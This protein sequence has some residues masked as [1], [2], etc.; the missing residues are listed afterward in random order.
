MLLRAKKRKE[1][2]DNI[3][4][5]TIAN[6]SL[7][8]HAYLTDVLLKNITKCLPQFVFWKDVDSVY[9][10]CN[11]N[12]AHFIGLE[13]SIDIVGKTD[14]DIDWL[15][16]GHTADFFQSGDKDVLAGHPIY[17]QEEVL[18]LPN[19]NKIHTQ[20]SKL[21]IKGQDGEILGVIGCF[22]DITEL[23]RKEK[24]A[25]KARKEAQIAN[26]SRMNFIS[27]MSHDLRTPLTGMLGMAKIISENSLD[28]KIVKASRYLIES[29]N[30]LLN[31]L[32]EIIE[33][34]QIES[35]H[36]PLKFSEIRIRDIIDEVVSLFKPT[37]YQKPVSLNICFDPRIPRCLIGDQ[38]RVQRVL[39]NL[40]SNAIKFTNQ[41]AIHITVDVAKFEENSLTIR[42]VVADTGIG[43]DKKDH[44]SIFTQFNRLTSSSSGAYPGSGLGLSIVER[45]IKDMR[46]SINLESEILKGSSFIC[47]I[48]FE[49]LDKNKSNG[50]ADFL[51]EK[52]HVS[53]CP[54]IQH[55]DSESL[56]Y[57]S[58]LKNKPS[59]ETTLSFEGSTV[60][61]VE[62]NLIAQ[63]AAKHELEKLHCKVDLAVD[64]KDAIFKAQKNNY[65]LIFMD[66]GLPDMTGFDAI[67]VIGAWESA[68]KCDYTPIVILTADASVQKKV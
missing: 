12:Y 47:L 27:N 52:E 66:V 30:I 42:L 38:H 15:E 56:L 23:K 36:L 11:D 2:K 41:G 22:T 59:K 32:N 10:G 37:I 61:L 44:A 20:L 31:I 64:G 40:I 35:G 68:I 14:Y 55:I 60:L 4:K 65:D 9:M 34:N 43:I 8:K 54:E 18:S 21:P 24:E 46:G 13:S 63:L 48:P 25:V 53:L 50:P 26:A 3:I 19:G 7:Q 1:A 57:D 67:Q 58:V 16:C 29:G 6:Q 51:F 33:I 28:E 45:F 49:T 5:L 39:L 17:N 62:D